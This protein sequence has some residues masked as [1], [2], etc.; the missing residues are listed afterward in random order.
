MLCC[1]VVGVQFR[2]VLDHRC[3]R[4]KEAH[5][6]IVTLVLPRPKPMVPP[7]TGRDKHVRVSPP[8]VAP[9]DIESLLT[10][11]YIVVQPRDV[12]GGVALEFPIGIRHASTA[13]SVIYAPVFNREAAQVLEEC[14]G[15]AE[16]DVHITVAV[17]IA[18]VFIRTLQEDLDI[19]QWIRSPT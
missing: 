2:K 8:R 14:A 18:I 10:G 17:N 19:W 9:R 5:S 1:A 15:V 11:V 3:T 7:K 4:W 16:H 13:G 12:R 6:F